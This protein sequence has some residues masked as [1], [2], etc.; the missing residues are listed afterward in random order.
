MYEFASPWVLC[1]LPL[2]LLLWFFM[3]RA[4]TQLPAAIRVPHYQAMFALMEQKKLSGPGHTSIRLFFLIW[5]LVLLAL[6]GPRW[7]GEPLPLHR[8]GRNI[9]LALDLSGSM[10]IPDMLLNGRPVNRLTVVK[11]TARE[12]VRARTG[13]HIGLILFG[14][15]AYLQTP[16]TYDHNNVLQRLDDASVGLAGQT[17]SIGDAIGLAVKHLQDV[18]AKSRVII[19]L[20]DGANNSGVLPPLKAAQIARLDN[21]KIY[22]IGLG[23]KS[24]SQ[25]LGDVFFNPNPAS[26]L[27]EETLESV[28]TTSGGRYFRATDPESLAAIYERINTLETVEQDEASVRPEQEYYPWPLGLALC[29]LF[30][31]LGKRGQLRAFFTYR[32]EAGA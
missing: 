3:Q 5:S 10:D 9:M 13:D 1:A 27:D 17:T 21:I 32:K 8:D 16:L 15:R 18:P 23:A 25:N 14:T 28:A 2:P 12:F 31:W 29:L 24:Q 20:T 26:D 4:S 30:Y 22:T 7:V 11:H 6:A 19:L